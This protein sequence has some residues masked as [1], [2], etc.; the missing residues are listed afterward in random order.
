MLKISASHTLHCCNFWLCLKLKVREWSRMAN[1]V[2]FNRSWEKIL[3]W[4][5]DLGTKPFHFPFVGSLWR[6][7]KQAT[8]EV[9]QLGWNVCQTHMTWHTWSMLILFALNLALISIHPLCLCLVPLV[10]YTI[11]R[12]GCKSRRRPVGDAENDPSGGSSS[13]LNDQSDKLDLKQRFLFIELA[14]FCWHFHSA[15]GSLITMISIVWTGIQH[16]RRVLGHTV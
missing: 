4:S 15:L 1:V 5:G 13:G 11:I 12:L 3:R 2:R 8:D 9:A 6:V 10:C 16:P 14:A 7:G